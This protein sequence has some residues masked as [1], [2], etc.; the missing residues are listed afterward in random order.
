MTVKWHLVFPESLAKSFMW[1]ALLVSFFKTPVGTCNI[2]ASATLQ[3]LI[4]TES[5][6]S[7]S[8]YNIKKEW[9]FRSVRRFLALPDC[10]QKWSDAGPAGL[11]QPKT[12][13]LAVQ[14]RA[15]SSHTSCRARCHQVNTKLFPGSSFSKH[16]NCSIE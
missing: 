8:L 4:S 12:R 15:G 7:P 5:F 11:N 1:K 9:V 16:Q 10:V 13:A 2:S 6:H 3:K 14:S